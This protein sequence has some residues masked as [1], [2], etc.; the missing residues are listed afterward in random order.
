MTWPDGSVH[1]VYGKGRAFFSEEGSL[2]RMSG[3]VLD[4]TEQKQVQLALREEEE[5]TRVLMS[6]QKRAQTELEDREIQFLSL[7]DSIPQ[8]VWMAHR[9][10]QIFWFNQR[11]YQYTGTTREEVEGWS[12]QKVH[13]PDVLPNVLERWKASIALG[14]FFEMEFPLKGA[15]GKFRWFL[16]RVSPVK[17]AQGEVQRWFGTN[18][19]IED[20]RRAREVLKD[21]AANLDELVKERTAEL[22]KSEAFLDSLIEN[23]P[24]M[25]F[26]KDAENLK[27]VRFNKAG[28]ELLGLLHSDLIGKNDYDFFPKEQADFFTSKDRAVLAGH[29]VVDIPEE[30][31]QTA[32]GE[33]IRTPERFQ[34]SVPT[35]GQNI[36]LAFQKILQRRRRQ[37]RSDY[38]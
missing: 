24:N 34:Y 31:I 17:N 18:T 11:W 15:D 20:Q 28:E 4:I 22:A 8:L 10:G 26:V 14:E 1:W 21:A 9:D 29:T 36:Y 5:R 35:V 23:L 37:T 6:D 32:T 3:T 7:A 16:T 13:D 25:V 30:L 12:W 19:D 33:R 38:V 27:F 2:I